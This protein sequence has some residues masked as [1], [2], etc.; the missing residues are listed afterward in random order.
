M[1]EEIAN[2]VNPMLAYGLELRDRLGY[3][4]RPDMAAEQ[5][6]L[7]GL[8]KTAPE[9][10]RWPDYGGDGDRWLGIRY[11]LACWVDEILTLH[12]PW[13]PEWQNHILEESLYGT[14]DRAWNFWAQAKRAQA[15][16]GTDAVEAY[17]LCVMLGFRG[18]GPERTETIASWCEGVKEQ[19]ARE[20]SKA[21]PGL[22]AELQS[23]VNASPRRTRERLR[24]ILFWTVPVVG[25]FIFLLLFL[26][27]RS[28]GKP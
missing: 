17:Y 12:S 19:L 13:G 22:P 5:A 16:P 27:V 10:Q 9:A 3:G 4:E 15:R 8:L 24:R 26:L 6:H 2:L 14:R 21:W 11:A 7:R 18:E 28:L 23:E 20:Q 25:V 1:R